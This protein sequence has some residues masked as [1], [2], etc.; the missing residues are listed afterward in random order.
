MSLFS[1]GTME[2]SLDAMEAPL[3]TPLFDVEGA[4][5]R[6]WATYFAWLERSIWALSGAGIAPMPPD[7]AGPVTV[8]FRP[9]ALQVG[10]G[11]LHAQIRT[12]EDL[13]SEVFVHLA[14]EH[15][16]QTLALVS[17]MFPPF[18]SQPGDTVGLQITGTTHVFS[19][20]G[21]RIASTSATLHA[22]AAAPL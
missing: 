18:E 3:R 14:V 4:L 6:P 13:G 8:G 1:D 5:T 9:E 16:D 22:G 20:D 11:P 7:A 2:V 15:Q 17:K 12:V 19:E 21:A 10:D